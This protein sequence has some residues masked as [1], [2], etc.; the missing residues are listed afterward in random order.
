VV[1]YPAAAEANDLSGD[2]PF[3]AKARRIRKEELRLAIRGI[4]ETR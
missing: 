4:F 2:E 3:S 1:F